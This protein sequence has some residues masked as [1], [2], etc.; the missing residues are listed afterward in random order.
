MFSRHLTKTL[1]SATA[2]SMLAACA[3]IDKKDTAE[4]S[5][6]FIQ[7]FEKDGRT[8]AEMATVAYSQGKFDKTL[9]YTTEAL[10]ANPR[11][12]QALLVGALAAEKM[13]RY[14]KARQYYEDLIVIN[15]DETSILG[16]SGVQ[17]EKM[18]DIAKANLRA[19]TIAQSNLTVENRDGT[20]HFAIAQDAGEL[21]SK[22]T[23]ANALSKKSIPAVR[24][25]PIGVDDIFT[26]NEQNIVSRFLILKELAEKDFITKEEFLSRRA[27]NIGGLLPLTK[28]APGVGV[29]Q[30]VPSPDLIIERL[31]ILKEGVENRAITPREF[32]VERDVIIEALMSPAPRKRIKNKAPSKNILDA[33][34]DLRRL[35]VL[36]DLDLITE[37]EKNIEKK[38]VEKYLGINH[39]P[40][41]KETQPTDAPKAEETPQ[42][43]EQTAVKTENISAP[44]TTPAKPQAAEKAPARTPEKPT[45]TNT[46]PAVTSPF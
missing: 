25:Q 23:I 5:N 18:A 41:P 39:T 33:A 46:P 19:I 3:F 42:P 22:A 10:K 20:K 1:L 30:P 36:Y 15:G 44:E 32:S 40:A 43:T 28:Q 21:Q 17:P 31:N 6:W 34:N 11:N 24:N 26:Q 9:E 2:L 37:S 45:E 7:L 29:D 12:G 14:N 4:E 8:Y 13:G 38:A 35:E 16:I 27:A